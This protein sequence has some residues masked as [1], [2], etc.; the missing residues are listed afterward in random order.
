MHLVSCLQI[1][2]NDPNCAKNTMQKFSLTVSLSLI[3]L[4][5][6]YGFEKSR[7]CS[8][9]RVSLTGGLEVSF[10]EGKRENKTH[11]AA[12]THHLGA[13][14]ARHATLPHSVRLILISAPSHYCGASNLSGYLSIFFISLCL[15]YRCVL[16]FIKVSAPL[17]I[18]SI[19]LNLVILQS[20]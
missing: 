9:P 18:V 6:G 11:G 10:R 2:S 13:A 19:I 4:G 3:L 5:G 16:S 1:H 20:P 8:S 12:E 7:A 15:F 14:G 17:I